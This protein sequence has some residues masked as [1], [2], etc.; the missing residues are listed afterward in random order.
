MLSSYSPITIFVQ[1]NETQSIMLTQQPAKRSL[2]VTIEEHVLTSGL[3]TAVLEVIHDIEGVCQPKFLR[4]GIPD[5]FSSSYGSQDS[6]LMSWGLSVGG[7]AN[8]IRN[9]VR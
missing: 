2:I 1:M 3:G 5:Q 7:I 6:L 4:L 9:K 8:S